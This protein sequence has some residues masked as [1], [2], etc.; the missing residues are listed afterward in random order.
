VNRP[1]FRDKIAGPPTGL[2]MTRV[3]GVL[4]CLEKLGKSLHF[5]GKVP[6]AS[7]TFLQK[8]LVLPAVPDQAGWTTISWV[9][10][11]G[12]LANCITRLP[13]VH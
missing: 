11:R 8:K 13:R 5:G 9:R 7:K 2:I 6:S 4:E 1:G 10:G 3:M 12:A